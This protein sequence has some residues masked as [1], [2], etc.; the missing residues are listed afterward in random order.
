MSKDSIN[1]NQNWIK[2]NFYFV[3]TKPKN[4]WT[5]EQRCL[6]S[7]YLWCFKNNKFGGNG[8]VTKYQVGKIC[9]LHKR[10]IKKN[11][12]DCI[13]TVKQIY[14][15]PESYLVLSEGDAEW[16][17]RIAY[18]G[19]PRD[20]PARQAVLRQFLRYQFSRAKLKIKK[21]VE[22]RIKSAW[23]YY[24][25]ATGLTF[26]GVRSAATYLRKAEII[27]F[28][29]AGEILPGQ[30]FNLD[31]RKTEMK[32]PC[33]QNRGTTSQKRS[34]AHRGTTS[35][36]RGTTAP[37]IGALL[38]SNRGTTSQSRGTTATITNN[39]S[40]NNSSSLITQVITGSPTARPETSHFENN[41]A[42]KFHK[43]D[44][45][46]FISEIEK[47]LQDDF[48]SKSCRSPAT[49]PPQSKIENKGISGSPKNKA[50]TEPTNSPTVQS[51]N[52]LSPGGAG[53]GEAAAAAKS[54]VQSTNSLSDGKA[55]G[56]GE[57]AAAAAAK[58]NNGGERERDDEIDDTYYRHMVKVG[59]PKKLAEEITTIARLRGICMVTFYQLCSQARIKHSFDGR[60]KH[61]GF[62]L[63]SLIENWSGSNPH[64]YEVVD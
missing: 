56:G 8:K 59:I 50:T 3:I 51:T 15:D 57:A 10:T 28:N 17:E 37:V 48:I 49:V 20:I 60:A 36:D 30:W 34:S 11:W 13:K 32:Y 7:S 61:Y 31:W 44:E 23:S 14:E 62:L 5:F 40:F 16:H 18:V 24:A 9:P 29:L 26:N 45:D 54:T 63:K 55:G 33:E 27:K 12:S 6:V 35:M 52:S 25:A 38:H 53:G 19:V 2:E 58:S 46:D 42:K 21:D 22:P 43:E 41:S 64:K 4:D 1:D 39:N 47:M